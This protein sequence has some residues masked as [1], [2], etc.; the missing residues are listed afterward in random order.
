MYTYK[1]VQ[2][3]PNII[4][5]AKKTNKKR[6]A[7]AFLEETVNMMASDG[8]DFYRT[9]AIGVEEAPGCFSSKSGPSLYYVIT[10]RKPIIE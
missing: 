4:I 6:A 10:F 1:M 3:P 2:I 7:A 9:D 5:N 8:W